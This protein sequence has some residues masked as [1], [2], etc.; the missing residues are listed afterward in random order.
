MNTDV[1]IRLITKDELNQLINLYKHLHTDDPDIENT[2]SIQELWYSI[3][4]DPSIYCIVAEQKGLLISTCNIT[5]I[6]N[7]TRN[8]RPYGLIENVVTHSDYR[9]LGLGKKV[10]QKAI[11][12]AKE[13]NC[14]KVMLLTGSKKEETLHFYRSVGFK[15][16]IKKGFIIN[17]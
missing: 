11:D 1:K 5:I 15:D 3:Y 12:I 9:N 6:K 2:E 13:N 4:N 10:L 17:F 16:D 8:A 14:Y 7:L